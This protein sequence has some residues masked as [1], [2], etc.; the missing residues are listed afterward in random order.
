MRRLHVLASAVFLAAATA[1]AA[2]VEPARTIVLEDIRANPAPQAAFVESYESAL[3]SIAAIA[4]HDLGLPKL[5]GVVELVPDRD[6]LHGVLEAHGADPAT[7]RGAAESMV[8]IGT[9]RAVYVNLAAFAPLNWNA[10]LAVLSHELT[11]VAQYEWSRGRRGTS[12]QWLREGFADWVQAHVLDRL[13]VLAR[14]GI[15]SRNGRFIT[16]PGSRERLPPLA[17]LANFP[18]WVALSSGESGRLL[19]PYAFIATDFL[20]R[21]HSLEAVIGYFRLFADSDDRLGNFERAFGESWS[22]FDAAFRD[23]LERFRFE[24]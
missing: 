13:G 23:H 1:C 14:D 19:Y 12:D 10:R 4:E 3:V 18:E 22:T 5:E 9:H 2:R 11:H 17:R 24:P 7:A 21:R 15:V 6:A 20:V 16:R 8:A